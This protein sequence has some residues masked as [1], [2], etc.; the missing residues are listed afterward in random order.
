LLGVRTGLAVH[1]ELKKK[2]LVAP[3]LST[4]KLSDKLLALLA[5]FPQLAE[6]WPSQDAALLHQYGEKG[7]MALL[8]ALAGNLP[9]A[10]AALLPFTIEQAQSEW[11]DGWQLLVCKAIETARL[12][13][14]KQME[15]GQSSELLL[16]TFYQLDQRVKLCQTRAQ[17]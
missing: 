4:Q 5:Q 10:S 1:R 16:A 12:S 13:M 11:Q 17:R 14:L 6:D 15:Q 9:N 3:A 7:V 8:T 2:Q